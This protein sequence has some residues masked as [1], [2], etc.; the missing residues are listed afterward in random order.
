MLSFGLAG[1]PLAWGRFVAALARCLQGVAFPG[2]ARLQ[3][4]LGDPIWCLIGAPDLRREL[5]AV[6]IWVI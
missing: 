5:G 4:Y 1:A 3:L 6:F 2:E